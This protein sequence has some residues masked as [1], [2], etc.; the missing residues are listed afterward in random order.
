MYTSEL[1]LESG[2]RIRL[3]EVCF[4]PYGYSKMF[5][6]DCCLFNDCSYLDWI[7]LQLM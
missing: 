2:E 7:V 5:S 3:N 1:V 4:S 6:F